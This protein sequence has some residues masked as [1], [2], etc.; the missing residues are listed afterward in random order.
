MQVYQICTSMSN[1]FIYDDAT[2]F[3]PSVFSQG[4]PKSPNTK[5]GP[6]PSPSLVPNPEKLSLKRFHTFLEGA[7]GRERKKEK[8]RE[9]IDE[10]EK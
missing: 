10:E 9:A 8:G 4:G 5:L 3:S 2:P 7:A 1:K 6:P